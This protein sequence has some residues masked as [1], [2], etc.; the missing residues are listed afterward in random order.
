ME[1]LTSDLGPPADYGLFLPAGE[2]QAGHWLGAHHC[3]ADYME[4]VSW[5][6]LFGIAHF[7]FVYKL[8]RLF[9][10]DMELLV[11]FVSLPGLLE[12]ALKTAEFSLMLV[13]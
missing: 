13:S 12:Q 1:L 4:G 10:F 11:D 2:G 7:L 6:A 8:C 9:F 5:D 3:L